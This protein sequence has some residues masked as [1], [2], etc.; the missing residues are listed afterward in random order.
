VARLDAVGLAAVG[1][2]VE[3]R[4]DLGML[5]SCGGELKMDLATTDKEEMA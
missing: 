4:G 5:T 3:L 1:V 2:D